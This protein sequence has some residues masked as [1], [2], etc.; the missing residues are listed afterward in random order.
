MPKVNKAGG[1]EGGEKPVQ[2]ADGSRP[3]PAREKKKKIHPHKGASSEPG[4]QHK[5]LPLPSSCS[6][7]SN[8]CLTRPLS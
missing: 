6:I 7:L 3:L 4:V 2:S 1:E 5:L 8:I